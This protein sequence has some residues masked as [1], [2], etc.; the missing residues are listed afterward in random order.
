MS[1]GGGEQLSRSMLERLRVGV[2]GMLVGELAPD[3]GDSIEAALAARLGCQVENLARDPGRLADVNIRRAAGQV[4]FRDSGPDE[5]PTALHPVAGGRAQTSVLLDG[6]LIFGERHLRR[7][8]AEY[9][10]HY[11]GHRPHRAR[12]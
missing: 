9:A 8:L 2:L 3:T 4:C 5:D 7:V 6:V 12:P 1:E 10:R 11:N